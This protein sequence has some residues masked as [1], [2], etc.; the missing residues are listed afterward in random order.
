[1]LVRGR[2]AVGQV[3]VTKARR[4]QTFGVRQLALG[5]VTPGGASG[6][7]QAGRG[8]KAC[9]GRPRPTR[10]ARSCFRFEC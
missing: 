7:V 8:P 3:Y 4:S 1:M 10:A 6:S 2:G 9:R 5:I